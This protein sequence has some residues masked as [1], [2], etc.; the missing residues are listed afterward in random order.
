LRQKKGRKDKPKDYEE[1]LFSSSE[2]KDNLN[3]EEG[4]GAAI[5]LPNNITRWFLVTF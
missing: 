2:D 5:A 1:D 3:P 4:V